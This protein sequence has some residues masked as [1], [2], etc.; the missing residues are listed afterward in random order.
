M[1]SREAK[2]AASLHLNQWICITGQYEKAL[3]R[4]GRD[5][6]RAYKNGSLNDLESCDHC[7]VLDGIFNQAKSVRSELKMDLE[8]RVSSQSRVGH[9]QVRRAKRTVG[10]FLSK[11]FLDLWDQMNI[12][13]YKESAAGTILELAQ[14]ALSKYD[15]GDPI[16]E[17][18]DHRKV[19]RLALAL[20]KEC[21]SCWESLIELKESHK[22]GKG[23]LS[24]STIT[25]QLAVGAGKFARKSKHGQLIAKMINYNETVE[26]ARLMAQ[27]VGRP[28]EYALR[29][30]LG[31][32][33]A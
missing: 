20:E 17:S 10:N 7:E 12:P 29:E 16:L 26:K 2:K 22:E 30:H 32:A 9:A 4:L 21:Q 3:M 19:C 28:E 33:P 15:N 13:K 18:E 11:R 14:R 8:I 23:S 31:F 24:I 27:F 25:V 6:Y 5:L 1:N